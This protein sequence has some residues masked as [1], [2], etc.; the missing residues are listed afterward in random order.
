M[1]VKAL[2]DKVKDLEVCSQVANSNNLRW[3]LAVELEAVA[4]L[5]RE[6]TLGKEEVEAGEVGEG[7]D[8]NSASKHLA[9]GVVRESKIL[10]P[11][12]VVATAPWRF[13]NVLLRVCNYK[14]FDQ[15]RTRNTSL[16]Q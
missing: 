12:A 9:L 15:N 4:V 8:L 5:I 3:V 10:I 7:L 2:A 16:E 13:L 11:D 1:L 14:N 6:E